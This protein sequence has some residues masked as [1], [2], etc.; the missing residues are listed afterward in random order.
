[1]SVA[2]LGNYL[3]CP[4]PIQVFDSLQ[5]VMIHTGHS[6][7]KKR[8]RF[9]VSGPPT[10]PEIVMRTFPQWS[11]YGIHPIYLHQPIPRV[12]PQMRKVH[13]RWHSIPFHFL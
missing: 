4:R 1:M 13:E 3:H 2:I 12:Q 9:G 5:K 7:W 6:V 11:L 10:F 8:N